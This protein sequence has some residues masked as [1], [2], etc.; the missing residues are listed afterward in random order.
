MEQKFVLIKILNRLKWIFSKSEVDFEMLKSILTL[1][2]TLDERKSPIHLSDGKEKKV[3]G[4]KANLLMLVFVGFFVGMMMTTPFDLYYKI[5]IVASMDLFFMVM[6]MVSDFSG[7]LLD[8][9]DKNIIMTKPVNQQTMNAARIIHIVYYMVAMFLALNLMSMVIGT[10]VYGPKILLA[11]LI[12]MIALSFLIVIITTIVYSALLERFSGEK[13]KDIINIFQI[14]LSITTILAY[15]VAARIF[16]FVDLELTINIK[17]WT[18]LMPPAWYAGL[19]KVVVEGTTDTTYIIMAVMGIVVPILAG[20]IL[21][22]WI[23]PKFESYLMKLQ[24]EDGIFISKNNLSSRIKDILFNV[25]SKDHTELAFMKFSDSNLSRDRKLKL[26]I[27]PNQAI[28]MLFPFIMLFPI[29]QGSDGILA[30]IAGL[31]GSMAYVAL[32]MS[33]MFFTTNFDFIQYSEKFEAAFIYDSFP[34]DNKNIIMTGALKAYYFKYVLPGMI[35]MSAIFIVLCGFESVFGVLVVNVMT[36]LLL[37]FKINFSRLSLPFSREMIP[38]GNKNMGATFVYMGICGAVAAV[39]FFMLKNNPL[40]NLGITAIVM[41]LIKV[42]F[43]KALK[44]RIV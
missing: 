3:K 37:G 41:V 36:I 16:E 6:Y 5:T 44:R 9:R 43:L 27:Y 40:F 26:M 1:K 32:Y 14:I 38:G 31:K 21:I 12:M 30:G 10:G 15:Q 23:F 8:V 11:F 34:I 17:W 33:T 19:F 25:F 20:L 39:H 28:S 22:K 2:L 7:V 13:L 42:A 29:I 35:V 4:L 18:Y 24:I